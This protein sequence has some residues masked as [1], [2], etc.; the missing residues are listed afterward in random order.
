M[1][2]GTVTTDLEKNDRAKSEW[3][4]SYWNSHT[5]LVGNIMQSP[6]EAVWQY[7]L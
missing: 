6:W 3:G 1:Q 2:N 5:P 4:V 7:L